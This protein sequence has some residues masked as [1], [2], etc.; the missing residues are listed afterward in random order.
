MTTGPSIDNSARARQAPLL[1]GHWLFGVNF[2]M[3]KDPLGTMTRGM[4]RLGDAVYLHLGPY[5][6]TLLRNPEHIKHVFVD[7]AAN[8]SKKTR[9][10]IKARLVLGDGLVTSEGELWQRQRRIAT[11]AFSRQRVEGFGKT[12][13]NATQQ[14]LDGWPSCVSAQSSLVNGSTDQISRVDQ[15]GPQDPSEAGDADG[16]GVVD[17]FS[18]MMKVTLRIAVQTLLGIGPNSD[19][20]RLSGA[21]SEVLER[22]N[23]LITN[24]FSL[25]AW[26]PLPKNRAFKRALGVL[27]RFVFDAIARRRAQFNESPDAPATDLLS[28]LLRAR[29]E[30]TGQGM[31]DRQLRDEAVTILIA[32]H[33]TTANA[34]SW[35]L[36]LLASH[37]QVQADLI[38]EI[39]QVLG[40]RPPLPEDIPQLRLTRAVID[41]ALR[42][43]PPA[44]MIGRHAVKDDTIGPYSIRANEFILISPYMTHRHPGLWDSADEFDP[45]RFMDGRSDRLPKF[46]YIPFGGGQRFCI[47]ANFALLQSVLMLASICQRFELGVVESHPI[48]P[49]A[50]ITLRPKFGIRLK[51]KKR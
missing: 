15:R 12:M 5:R 13:V 30:Q 1:K 20:E 40:K 37:P 28:I 4:R 7:N 46:A 50:M 51:V 34:L 23:A 31:G 3:R 8:Y 25:P 38:R 29:D 48:V 43:Y 6:A 11:P 18:E 22:T 10:Y 24:P 16:M 41:E 35:A 36:Y 44:W 27:D 47:G 2:Q 32:G 19:L 26:V 9:G 45:N 39:Q 17:V 33:E 21:V 49:Y 42:L 14:M